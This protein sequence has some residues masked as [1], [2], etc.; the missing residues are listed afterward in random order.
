VKECSTFSP[1]MKL[2]KKIKNK[3][4]ENLMTKLIKRKRLKNGDMNRGSLSEKMNKLN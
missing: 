1:E 2:K 3:I 4:L